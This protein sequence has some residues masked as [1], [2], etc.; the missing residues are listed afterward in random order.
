MGWDLFYGPVYFPFGANVL[1]MLENN[2]FPFVDGGFYKF[3][4][5]QVDL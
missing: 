4:L 2:I 5:G 1:W 3:Q